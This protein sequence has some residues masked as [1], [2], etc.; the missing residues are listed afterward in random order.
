MMA[1]ILT[2]RANASGTA[3]IELGLFAPILAAMLVGLIDLST[4]YSDK[5]HL[6]QVSQRI[7]ER[8]QQTTFKPSMEEA[9]EDEAE[10]AAG[11]GS[12]AEVTWWLECDGE[13]MTGTTA[14]TDGCDDDE[15]YAR[16]VQ[17]DIEK[18]YTPIIPA[19][20]VGA[21]RGG[22]IE[23]HGVAGIRIQ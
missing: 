12:V 14:Y 5:L 3:T 7:V 22:V 2:L 16:Y 19:Q 17:L 13:K 6:E 4:A 23:L 9:I 21:G 15:T 20:Y 10:A 11:T 18:N 8:V 1:R